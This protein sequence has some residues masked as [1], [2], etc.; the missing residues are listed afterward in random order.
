M[1][2]LEVKTMSGATSPASIEISD[3]WLER[4]KG[5]QAVKESVVAF[6]AGQRS[7]T[8]STKNRSLVTGSTR[9][10]L[11]RGGGVVF[12]PQPRSYAKKVNIKVEKLALKR[13]FTDRLDAGEIIVVDEIAM[14]TPKT[15]EFVAFL[16][17]IGV[18]ETA[19]ILVDNT[20]LD[21]VEDENSKYGW[22][23]SNL[24]LASRN[25]GNVIVMSAGNVNAYTLMQGKK[26]VITSAG[27]QALGQR[28]A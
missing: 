11:W 13:V 25:L 6:M 12:G 22:K 23:E 5:A 15:K 28:L 16:K 8:A 18:E 1:A 20:A 26:V 17:N 24:Y 4:E 27:L 21:P 3:S 9:S 19:L 10:P 14:T 2:T 7:G